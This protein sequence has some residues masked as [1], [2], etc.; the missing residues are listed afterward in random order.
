LVKLIEEEAEI[1]S[2]AKGDTKDRHKIILGFL[3]QLQ[4]LTAK[5]L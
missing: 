2:S 3:I 1:A 5:E 4:V